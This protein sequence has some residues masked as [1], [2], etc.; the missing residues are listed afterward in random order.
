[1]N[2]LA[3]T[4]S[5]KNEKLLNTLHGMVLLF[6]PFLV[7]TYIF[8]VNVISTSTKVQRLPALASNLETK[9]QYQ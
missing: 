9:V 7:I 4:L 8:S 3:K 2:L 1:M 5:L 6:G